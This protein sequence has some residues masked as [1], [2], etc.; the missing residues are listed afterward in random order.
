MAQ[1]HGPDDFL[2]T[3]VDGW[4]IR[5]ART[6]EL[7]TVRGI[8][9]DA[10]AWLRGREVRQW[11]DHFNAESL[12]PAIEAD[13]TWLAFHAGRALA[14]VTVDDADPAW[15]DRPGSALY[16]HRLAVRTHGLGLGRRLIDWA[17]GRARAEGREAL[18]LDCVAS[19]DALCAYYERF[20]FAECGTVLVGGS[21]GQRKT[22]TVQTAVRRFEYRLG[23]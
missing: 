1:A 22:G 6:T 23:A 18:R 16:L 19:N 15:S 17:F 12:S 4:T 3:T 10:A 7:D 9:D 5:R 13:E 21:P 20:G 2:G 11:P 14:T 8:L